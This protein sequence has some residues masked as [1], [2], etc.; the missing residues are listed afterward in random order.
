[1]NEHERAFESAV[2]DA[3]IARTLAVKAA[4]AALNA[5]IRTAYIAPRRQLMHRPHFLE[6]MALRAGLSCAI[7]NAIEHAWKM[8]DSRIVDIW[9]IY[10]AAIHTAR[11]ARDE[12]HVSETEMQEHRDQASIP[13]RRIKPAAAVITTSIFSGAT[14]CRP[15]RRAAFAVVDEGAH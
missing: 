8:Y 2:K 12:K 4:K 3:R 5:A 1:M 15:S 13:Q 6:G 10:G 7:G 9:E 11:N 14:S